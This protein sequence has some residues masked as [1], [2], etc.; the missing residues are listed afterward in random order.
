MVKKGRKPKAKAKAKPPERDRA[1]ETPAEKIARLEK[2]NASLRKKNDE[3]EMDR[4]ILRRAEAF[5]A[6]ESE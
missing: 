2:E 4:A 1:D 6:K 5:F 3:L